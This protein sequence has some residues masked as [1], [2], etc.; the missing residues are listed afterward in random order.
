MKKRK[1]KRNNYNSKYSKAEKSETYLVTK[2]TD[3]V[4]QFL[5][6]FSAAESNYI[7]SLRIV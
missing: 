3:Y 2:T 5:S 6:V 4:S 1:P 7:Y